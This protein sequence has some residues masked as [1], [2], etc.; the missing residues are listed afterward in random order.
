[1]FDPPPCYFLQASCPNFVATDNEGIVQPN[2][3]NVCAKN[4]EAILVNFCLKALRA[5]PA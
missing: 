5:P 3:S 2:D 4:T 1:M